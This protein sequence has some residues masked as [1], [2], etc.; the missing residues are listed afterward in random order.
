MS[1]SPPRHFAVG[2]ALLV[3][4]DAGRRHRLPQGGADGPRACVRPRRSRRR[5]AR[6]GSGRPGARAGSAEGDRVTAGQLI[7]RLDTRDTRTG[8]CPRPRRTRPG[9][10]ATAAAAG[11]VAGRGHPPGRG[12]GDRRRGRLGAAE[13]ELAMPQADLE[14]FEQLLQGQRRLAQAAR[15]RG[16]AP[17]AGARARAGRRASARGDR[18]GAAPA[19]RPAP[20]PRKSRR[21]GP[22]SPPSTRRS[23][24]SRSDR[25]RDGG[26]AVGRQRSPSSSSNAG[27]IVAPARRSSSSS[28][29]ITPG[30]TSTS[31]SRS[32]RGCARPAGD[33][34]HRR[35]RRGLPGRVTFISPRR[36]SRRATSRRPRS[37]R[38]SI[39]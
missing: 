13:A 9:R 19:C 35:R 16:G 36:S 39:A 3:A 14:R 7:A 11:G 25:R 31:K 12:A 21:P 6:R 15:R 27:E 26:R 18:A 30:R 23:P 38:S 28:I 34:R 20:G 33:G 5:P 8:D 1:Q 32:C 10:R 17:R 37:A 4:A 2:L 22:A 29:S 24:R